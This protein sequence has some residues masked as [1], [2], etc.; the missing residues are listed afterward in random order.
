VGQIRSLSAAIVLALA[1]V[2]SFVTSAAVASRAY[3]RRGEQQV[4]LARTLEVTGSAKQ[5]IVSDLALWT[6]RTGGEGKRL[7]EAFRALEETGAKVSS[8]LEKQ[9]FPADAVSPGPIR[10][11]THYARDA[12]GNETRE[13]AAYRL[14]RTYGIR[15]K[16]VARVRRASSEV[17]ELLKTGAHVESLS[18]EFVYTRLAELKVEML[19]RA[20]ADARDRA[21]RIARESGCRVASVKDARAGVLQITPPWSTEVSAGGMNDT[22]SIEKDVTAVMRL[23]LV[24]EGRP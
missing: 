12:K 20:A 11:E 22:S 2:V 21:E 23:T 24:I 6:I 8:F 16:D 5:P 9:G 3:L 7:E 18:P 17:T 19:G 4:Q 13:V 10:T 15:T 14:V 1:V